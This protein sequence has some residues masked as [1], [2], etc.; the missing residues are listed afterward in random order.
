M[1]IT[2]S[3][4]ILA[5]LSALSQLPAAV[6]TSGTVT[7]DDSDP[8]QL[9]RVLRNN[10]PSVWGTVKPFPGIASAASTFNY[11]LVNFNTSGFNQIQITYVH[12]SGVNANIFGVAYDGSFNAGN[13]ALNYLGDQGNSVL[14]A[15]PGPRIFQLD[16]GTSQSIVL[17]FSTAATNAFGVVGYTVEGFNSGVP[18]PSTLGSV[19][20]ALGLLAFLRHRRN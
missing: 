16:T 19:G 1:T 12:N 7:L 15:S 18:E 2:R 10:V 14:P 13:L 8:T 6:I 4:T 17:A 11:E 5:A 20:A 3:F 9:G